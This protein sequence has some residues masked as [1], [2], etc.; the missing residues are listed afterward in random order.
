MAAKHCVD[1]FLIEADDIVVNRYDKVSRGVDS[2]VYDLYPNDRKI[3][4]I[5]V[6]GD[7]VTYSAGSPEFEEWADRIAAL[8]NSRIEQRRLFESNFVEQ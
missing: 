8:I 5:E 2:V 1:G 3:L 7:A 4:H 6:N